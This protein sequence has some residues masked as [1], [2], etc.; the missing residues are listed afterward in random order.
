MN[1]LILNF[2]DCPMLDEFG[3]KYIS[4]IIRKSSISFLLKLT[5]C[6]DADMINFYD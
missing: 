1:K 3:K 4:K 2:N 5:G 6:A